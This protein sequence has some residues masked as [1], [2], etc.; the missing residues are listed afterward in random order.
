MESR[1]APIKRNWPRWGWHL[2]PKPS[3]ENCHWAFLNN[4]CLIDSCLS[5]QVLCALGYAGRGSF[6]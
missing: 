4:S 3:H 6:A 5:T 1:A 2:W